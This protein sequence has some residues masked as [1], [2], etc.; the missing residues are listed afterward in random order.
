MNGSSRFSSAVVNPSV[1]D[2]SRQIKDRCSSGMSL[3]QVLSAMLATRKLGGY[4]K[5]L[6]EIM[7]LPDGLKIYA[8]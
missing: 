8:Q 3:I 2:K 1:A 6:V 7:Q 4:C 5:L